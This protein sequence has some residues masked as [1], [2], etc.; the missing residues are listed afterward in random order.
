MKNLLLLLLLPF[1]L[2]SSSIPTGN[3]RYY[4][5]L[6]V[7]PEVFRHQNVVIIKDS[8]GKRYITMPTAGSNMGPGHLIIIGDRPS[9]TGKF[10]A[11]QVVWQTKP[12]GWICLEAGAAGEFILGGHDDHQRWHWDSFI[13][14]AIY[15]IAGPNSGAFEGDRKLIYCM[16]PSQEYK[17]RWPDPQQPPVWNSW[18]QTNKGRFPFTCGNDD[19]GAKKLGQKLHNGFTDVYLPEPTTN[20]ALPLWGDGVYALIGVVDPDEK[21]I[22]WNETDNWAFAVVEI[23][24]SKIKVLFVVEPGFM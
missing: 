22:E 4:P 16:S 20:C 15:K 9:G 1:L 24:G 14:Y 19:P 5:N 21:V 10:P 23:R 17:F 3:I 2:A 13:D 8:T 12:Q 7:D 18:V 6:R 11:T